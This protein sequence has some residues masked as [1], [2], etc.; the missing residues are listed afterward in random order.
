[1][2]TSFAQCDHTVALRIPR[3]LRRSDFS[4]V[5]LGVRTGATL[6]LEG[7]IQGPTG[8]SA[9]LGCANVGPRM[10]TWLGVEF[11]HLAALAAVSETRS[12]RGAADELGYVQSAVSQQL[13]RL[14]KLVGARLVERSRGHAQVEL[15]EAGETLLDHAESILS[16]LSAAQSDLRALREGTGK[17]LRVG[18]IQCLAAY[19]LPRVLALCASR[20]PNMRIEVREGLSDLD[21][22]AEVESGE[23]DAA[24]AEL[25]LEHGPFDSRELMVDPLQL[26]VQSDSPLARR[27]ATPS[28][29]E[30]AAQPLVANT[31]WRMNELVEAEMR[32]A[33]GQP[34]RSFSAST[35]AAVQALVGAGLGV[36]IMPR[37]AIDP[38]DPTTE[39]IDLNGILQPR[40]LVLYWLR[41]RHGSE[42]LE[43]FLDTARSVCAVPQVAD[44]EPTDG[45]PVRDHDATLATASAPASAA[46]AAA[47]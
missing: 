6:R 16:Q 25:P 29:R 19:L 17:T 36:A 7:P 40:T 37:L 44:A 11:R 23:L 30:I 2:I 14:E 21:L 10:E 27:T 39:A 24:F 31:T 3:D 32:V 43:A 12:F 47:I 4:A 34:E 20:F 15:T 28:L 33:G 5:V 41:D 22:F 13:A 8:C 18:V 46:T 26:L 42:A 38:D 35:N 45:E 9:A 1:V